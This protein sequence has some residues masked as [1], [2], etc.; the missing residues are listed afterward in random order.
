MNARNQVT[1]GP[2]LLDASRESW[3]A[4]Y[5]FAFATILTLG[6]GYYWLRHS[7]ME[8]ANYWLGLIGVLILSL[9]SGGICIMCHLMGHMID[10]LDE[11]KKAS[12]VSSVGQ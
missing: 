4:Y 8:G 2:E 5:V 6:G 7:G 1:L 11:M 12:P 9:V 3:T 10:M